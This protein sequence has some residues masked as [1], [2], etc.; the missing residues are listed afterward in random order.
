MYLSVRQLGV[1]KK[2]PATTQRLYAGEVNADTRKAISWVTH[3]FTLPLARKLIRVNGLA[4]SLVNGLVRKQALVS[5]ACFVCCAAIFLPRHTT[6]SF[7]S[8]PG[9]GS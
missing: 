3:P 9:W 5:G 7:R 8:L 2:R 6:V 4:S 1:K